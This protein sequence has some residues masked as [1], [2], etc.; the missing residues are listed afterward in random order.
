MKRR[1]EELLEQLLKTQ[2]SFKD[3][4]GEKSFKGNGQWQ[5]RGCRGGRGRGRSCINKFNNED[6]NHQTFRGR[7]HGQQGGRGRG[8]YQGTN[9]MRY[10]KSKI[11]C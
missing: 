3:F 11:K 8:A 9:E 5:G 6:K 1:K 10:D 4:G 7:G 2:A